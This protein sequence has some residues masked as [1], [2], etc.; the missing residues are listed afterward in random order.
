MAGWTEKKMDEQISGW[1]EEWRDKWNGWMSGG[2]DGQ[3][4]GWLD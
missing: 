1:M 3:T 4:S 2:V